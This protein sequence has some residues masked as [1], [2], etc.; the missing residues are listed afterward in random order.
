MTQ[1]FQI[2]SEREKGYLFWPSL[3]KWV[4]GILLLGLLLG[5]DSANAQEPKDPELLMVLPPLLDAP[6]EVGVGLGIRNIPAIDEHEQVFEI[7]AD[8]VA[9]WEDKR[10]VFDPATVGHDEKIYQ[11][12]AVLEKL[13]VNIWWPDFEITDSREP[14]ERMYMELSIQADGTVFYRERFR[15]I[16]AQNF[17][18]EQFPFDQH[19]ISLNVEPFT[20]DKRYVVFYELEEERLDTTWQT[21]EW[22]IE[23]NFLIIDEDE[24][25]DYAGVTLVV[26]ISRRYNFY[27]TNF[28]LPLVLIVTISWAVFW[29]DFESSSLADQLSV[30]F[31]S[32]LTVVAFDFISSDS[33]PK[34]PYATVLDNIV[35]ISYICLALTVLENIWGSSLAKQSKTV[36]MKRLDITSRFIFPLGYYGAIAYL[37]MSALPS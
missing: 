2:I 14:R 1:L 36:A 34:L 3:N 24:E 6:T 15:A 20:Y 18:F 30:S 17:D 22:E 32:V 33:L 13:K 5:V 27:L 9:I 4:V 8:L 29:M 19:D 10:L 16:I 23:D 12:E 37:I 11:G 28:I 26:P 35:T 31:T 7:D 21:N 25:S